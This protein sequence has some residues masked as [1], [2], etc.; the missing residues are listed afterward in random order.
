MNADLRLLPELMSARRKLS[1]AVVNF[2]STHDG[3]GVA[4]F[5]QIHSLKG[6]EARS[7]LP[8]EFREQVFRAFHIRLTQGEISALVLLLHREEG[9]GGN[10]SS[11]QSIDSAAFLQELTSLVRRAKTSERRKLSEESKNILTRRQLAQEK[12]KSKLAKL[13]VI[14]LASSWTEGDEKSAVEKIFSAASRY[15]SSQG[16]GALQCFWRNGFLDALQLSEQ[17]KRS[18]DVL[19][20]PQ[21]L[22][23]IMSIFDPEGTGYIATYDF[24]SH[25]FRMGRVERDR[26]MSARIM[27]NEERQRRRHTFDE[28]MRGKL[29]PLK[30]IPLKEITADE[31][32]SLLAKLRLIAVSFDAKKLVNHGESNFEKVSNS[33][34]EFYESLRRHFGLN[35]TAGELSAAVKMFDLDR[36]GKISCNEFSSV[37][38]KLRLLELS[39]KEDREREAR[40]SKERRKKEMEQRQNEKAQRLLALNV[41]P[42]SLPR[43]ASSS[44]TFSEIEYMTFKR[45]NTALQ[46]SS[47]LPKMSTSKLFPDCS[48]ETKVAPFFYC[49]YILICD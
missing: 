34:E 21:E 14:H 45:S 33:P 30:T 17:L 28:Q 44:P 19:L 48:P 5:R 22:A 3:T 10:G 20:T 41:P 40:E 47:R 29:V 4:Q 46:A 37:F 32:A 26:Q 2:N 25:F 13:S 38:Y 27:K 49:T 15:D 12:H 1:N 8:R 16:E 42:L 18:F 36:D 11:S 6:F 9:G 23:A 43:L 39:R 7:L 24:I 35:L 31:E